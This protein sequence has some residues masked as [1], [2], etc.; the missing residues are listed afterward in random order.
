[1]RCRAPHHP[2]ARASAHT[3]HI[4]VELALTLKGHV[5]VTTDSPDTARPVLDRI[6]EGVFVSGLGTETPS[7]TSTAAHGITQAGTTFRG[8]ST[9]VFDGG[10]AI[11]FAQD[12]VE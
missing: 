7:V 1:L 2:I 5:A 4:A 8:P 6:S 10:G 12:G 9:M 11:D 3:G